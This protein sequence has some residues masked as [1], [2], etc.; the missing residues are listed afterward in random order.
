MKRIILAATLL[1]LGTLSFSQEQI[2]IAVFPFE[3][4]ANILSRDESD[5]F[6]NV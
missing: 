2:A 6:Y 5:T 3:D 4:R 1:F